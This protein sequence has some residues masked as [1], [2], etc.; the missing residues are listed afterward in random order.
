L[1]EQA[2]G[3]QGAVLGQRSRRLK[4]LEKASSVEPQDALKKRRKKSAESS[5]STKASDKA[6]EY[7]RFLQKQWDVA[8]V[9]A[10]E[11][12]AWAKEE[13]EKAAATVGATLLA[14]YVLYKYSKG[15]GNRSE[16]NK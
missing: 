9:K 10:D 6:S 16:K 1:F 2:A 7:S 12:V 4:K 13:K 3:R 5:W 11:V 14:C 8:T 15:S